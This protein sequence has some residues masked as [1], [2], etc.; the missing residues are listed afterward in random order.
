MKN[1]VLDFIKSQYKAMEKDITPEELNPIKEYMVK[2]FTESK[3]KNGAWLGAILG[4]QTNGVD[5]FNN[6]IE[7][8]NSITVQD[9]MNFMKALNAQGNYRVLTLDPAK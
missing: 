1:E 4:Y 9:V 3:E 6:N 2:S 7:T 5:T 8:M